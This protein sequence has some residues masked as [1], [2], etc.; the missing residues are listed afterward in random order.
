MTQASPNRLALAS[1]ALAVALLALGCATPGRPIVQTVRIETPGCDRVAC[2]LSNDQGRWPVPRT[3]GT[4]TL[5]SSLAPLQVG[6]RAG[7]GAQGGAG[8]AH[9][10][11]GA[12]ALA[13]IAPL[14]VVGVVGGVAGAGAAG[15]APELRQRSLRYPDL[16]IVPMSCPPSGDPTLPASAAF[17]LVVRGLWVAR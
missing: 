17:G 2:E 14:G 8:L 10:A 13:F 15:Q 11:P 4:V 5:T 1:A 12:S 7:D 16:I 9:A 3:P 6:C